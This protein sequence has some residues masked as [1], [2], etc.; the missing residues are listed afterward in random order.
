ML[1]ARAVSKMLSMAVQEGGTSTRESMA[2]MVCREHV[3]GHTLAV[4]ASPHAYADGPDVCVP[5]CT[6]RTG[7]KP[8]GRKGGEK[9]REVGRRKGRPG[10]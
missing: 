9:R 2:T 4:S 6:L 1:A 10:G 8:G 3:P 7:W 5:T